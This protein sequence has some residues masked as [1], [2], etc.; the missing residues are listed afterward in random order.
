MNLNL[1]HK[2]EYQSD[3]SWDAIVSAWVDGESEI[4]TEDLN[5]PYGR[6]VWDNYHLIGDVIRSDDLSIRPSDMFYARL[7]KAIDQ[8]PTIIAPKPKIS[9]S[10]IKR[11]AGVAVAAAVFGITW[12]NLQQPMSET[13]VE[14]TITPQLAANISD[15]NLEQ[16]FNDYYDAHLDMIGSVPSMQ[17]SYVGGNPQ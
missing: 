8:E 17:V 7:S 9:N 1:N 12:V 5:T 4:R 14:Q 13:V 15:D 6:Q 3:Q 10:M 16:S 2:H 11:I